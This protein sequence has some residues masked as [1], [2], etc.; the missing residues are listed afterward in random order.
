MVLK[1]QRKF[2]LGQT[3]LKWYD[4]KTLKGETEYYK[5]ILVDQDKPKNKLIIKLNQSDRG[6]S[7]SKP[8]ELLYGRTGDSIHDQAIAFAYALK[9]KIDEYRF[10]CQAPNKTVLKRKVQRFFQKP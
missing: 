5:M 7:A 6:R 9:E 1:K 4:G 3:S 10:N 2:C 8:I